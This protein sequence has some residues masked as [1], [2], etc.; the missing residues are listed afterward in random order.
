MANPT[1]AAA[2][3]TATPAVV[4]QGSLYSWF[5]LFIL[6]LASIV[7]YI[8]RQIINLLIEPIKAD[9]GVNDTQIGLLQGFSF[10]V[11]YAVLALPLA[12][13][14]DRGKRV[15]IIF[16]GAV[17]WSLA[18]FACGMA[19]S[20]AVLFIARMFV[21][22]GEAT[23]SPSGYSLISDY[24]R[25]SQIPLAISIFTGC[26]FV[27]SGVAYIFGGALI[28]FL[29][30]LDRIVLPMI[31]E[32][33]VWQ[34]SFILVAIPS[35]LLILLI[36]LIRE[37]PR[38]ETMS[39]EVATGS[40]VKDVISHIGKQPRLFCGVFVG[41]TLM[42]AAS[43]ALNLWTPTYFI[44]THG[45]TPLQIG[46][47][48][49][50]IVIFAS[51][52]GV[53]AGGLVASKLMRMGHHEANLSVPAA[54]AL[55]AIPLMIAFPLVGS[56]TLA[57][58]CLA[59]ALFF[60]AVPFGCGTAVL[61]LISPNRIRAQIVALYLL[62]ANLL[63]FTLGPTA[64]GML[65]DY[66]FQDPALIGYSLSIAPAFF[67]GLGFCLVVWSIPRYRAVVAD[68]ADAQPVAA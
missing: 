65:T 1:D 42:A 16:Y 45:W 49:G 29:S 28:D 35:L 14:A 17:C 20:F 10:V 9:F 56:P 7:S 26:T 44:R 25:K 4:R 19:M 34:A 8:D 66:V 62:T 60:A 32:R 55:F 43:F 3:V 36:S 27:G 54:A 2:T 68:A 38:S 64:V 50:T 53:L 41:L 12:R 52:G 51:A 13:L 59:P 40:T 18:T 30:N 15:N 39:G 21:G 11:F 67:L 37:P 58:F 22:I 61:P 33:S 57:L 47:I 6:C 31:G 5:V 48:F 46:S 23:L 63:G 24:F